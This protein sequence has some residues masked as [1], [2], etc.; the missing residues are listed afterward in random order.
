MVIEFASRAEMNMYQEAKIHVHDNIPLPACNPERAAKRDV[1]VKQEIEK[2]EAVNGLGSWPPASF[3][4]VPWTAEQRTNIRASIQ[5]QLHSLTEVF[6][7]T[8]E[9]V[10][11]WLDWA[12]DN[13]EIMESHTVRSYA[14][15]RGKNKSWDHTTKV[16]ADDKIAQLILWKIS[17]RKRNSGNVIED[18]TG[19]SEL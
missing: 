15:K 5:R 17:D 3:I 8:T 11:T 13:Y 4:K 14:R 1:Y 6:N 10:E 7:L 9:D 16:E 18:I 2:Y 19:I 12:E